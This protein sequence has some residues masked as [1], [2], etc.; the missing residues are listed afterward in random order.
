[1]LLFRLLR[2]YGIIPL[3]VS[4]V[5]QCSGMI[6]CAEFTLA[7]T[8]SLTIIALTHMVKAIAIVKD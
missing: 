2:L 8:V 1:M 5:T 7:M 6:R 4:S 3:S